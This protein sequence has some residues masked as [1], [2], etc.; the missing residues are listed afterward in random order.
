MDRWHQTT[1]EALQ[2]H[3]PKRGHEFPMKNE[4]NK[5]CAVL[6]VRNCDLEPDPSFMQFLKGGL[7][8]CPVLAIDC[9]DSNRCGLQV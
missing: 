1:L 5:T 8:I 4:S 3:I 2:D 9:S 7:D 6:S